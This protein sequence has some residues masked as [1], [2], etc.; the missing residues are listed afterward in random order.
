MAHSASTA[1]ARFAHACSFV[2]LAALGN[3]VWAP[4]LAAQ[5]KPIA[6]DVKWHLQELI[7]GLRQYRVARDEVDWKQVEAKTLAAA[8]G[9]QTIPEAFPAIRVALMEIKD[10]WAAYRAATGQSVTP[11]PFKCVPTRTT[12]PAMP[13][14]VGYLKVA[15]IPSR[16]LRAEREAAVALRT[17]IKQGDDAG[18][19]AWIVDLR[20]HFMGSIPAAV[21]GVAPLMGDGTAFKMQYADNSK[22]YNAN[23][24]SIKING[25]EMQMDVGRFALSHKKPRVAVLVD[26]GTAGVGEL[27]TIAFLG[28][29]DTRVFGVPTCGIPPIRLVPQKLKNGAEYTLSSMRVLDRLDRAYRGPIEPQERIDDEAALFTRAIAWVTTGK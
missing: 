3:A 16:G 22:S 24:S 13:S 26:G 21:M 12:A 17:A 5:D 28:K 11:E 23:E 2:L 7:N 1:V 20:G 19:T 29:D 8:A 6:P 15:S 18:A 9:A 27:L 4:R 25:Q 14:S 10:P